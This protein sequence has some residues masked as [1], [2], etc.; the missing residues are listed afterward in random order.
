MLDKIGAFLLALT[1]KN[2]MTFAIFAVFVVFFIAVIR[3]HRRNR[4]DWRDLIVKPHSNM[5]SL[6]KVLQ[7]VG[8]I[9]ATWVV[10]Q[11]TILTSGKISW[12][13][14]SVYLAYVASIEGFSKWVAAKYSLP[15]SPSYQRESSWGESPAVRPRRFSPSSGPP[16]DDTATRGAKKT[17]DI[18]D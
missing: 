4:L 14:F 9:V 7:L 1:T 11:T 15:T 16:D 3:E 8:G 17:P 12:E 18:D 2:V 10:V 13:I 6:T 5:I